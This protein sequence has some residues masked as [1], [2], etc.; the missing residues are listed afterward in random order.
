MKRFLLGI[1]MLFSVVS[2]LESTGT[3]ISETLYITFDESFRDDFFGA[4]S[5]Y[6]E[7]PFMCYGMLVFGNKVDK[8]DES[9]VEFKGGFALSCLSGDVKESEEP[10]SINP[11]RAYAPIGRRNMYTVYFQS[12]D[13]P[14]KDVFFNASSFGTCVMGACSVNNTVEVVDFVKK[15][16]VPGDRITLTATGF[17]AG[18]KTGSAEIY[19]ADYSLQKDSVVTNWT[20]FNLNK[21]GSIDAIDFEITSSKEVPTSFCLDN[22]IATVTLSY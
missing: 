2:C 10:T 6:T 17:L 20:S 16:F 21:L 11:F 7:T 22:M 4:D 12:D 1:A 15:N 19:L 5:V 8:V 14:E 13:M 9:T 18:E 3:K